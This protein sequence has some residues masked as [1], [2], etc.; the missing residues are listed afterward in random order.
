[1]DHSI[2]PASADLAALYTLLPIGQELSWQ[3]AGTTISASLLHWCFGN[4]LQ[5]SQIVSLSP[6][7]PFILSDS[8]VLHRLVIIVQ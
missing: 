2:S 8:F 4:C 5:F 1:M 6:L 7:L 3:M